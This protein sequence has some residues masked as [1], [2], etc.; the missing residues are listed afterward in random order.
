MNQTI[1]R[2]LKVIAVLVLA[3]LAINYFDIDDKLYDEYLSQ[4]V[5]REQQAEAIMLNQYELVSGPVKLTEAGDQVSG[6]TWSP[7][8][9]SLY[10]VARGDVVNV[11]EYDRQGNLKRKLKSNRNI[12]VEGITWA[13]ND[14]FIIVNERQQELSAVQIAPDTVEVDFTDVPTFTFG[15]GERGNKG[16]EG[17]AWDPDDQSVYVV[18]ERDPAQ[19]YRIQGFPGNGQNLTITEQ[20][21]MTQSLMYFNRDL[22]GMH[23]DTVSRH[24]VVLS[25]ESH[26]LTELDEEGEAVSVMNLEK[27]WH[28]LKETIEQP[29]GVAMDREGTVFIVGEPND[30]YIFKKPSSGH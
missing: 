30:L 7:V 16:F 6:V 10:V 18:K 24:F 11:L 21:L 3:M 20:D 26:S 29:E 23:Y 14:T 25:D 15:V 8:T 5:S 12:D 9:D 2:A 22:S 27:G 13:G 19:I 28:D 4:T 17:I 1:K